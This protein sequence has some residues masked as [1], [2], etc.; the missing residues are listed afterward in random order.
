MHPTATVQPRRRSTLIPLS[1]FVIAFHLFIGTTPALT[2]PTSSSFDVLVPLPPIPGDVLT[3]DNRRNTPAI[4]IGLR[5]GVNRSSY[6]NDRYLDNVQLDVGDVSGESDIYESGAGFGYTFGSEVEYP[7]NAGLSLVGGVEYNHAVFGAKGPV[8]EPCISGSDTTRS[9]GS[10]VHE[11]TGT[12]N[13]LKFSGVGKLSFSKLYVLLG[14]TGEHPLSSKL[15]RTRTLEGGCVYADTRTASNSE[16]GPIPDVT[17]LHFSLRLG[18]GWRYPLTSN[19]TFSPE[20]ALDFGFNA[21]NKSKQSDLGI[22]SLLATI[23][24]DL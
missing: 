14:L 22:Y 12:I 15:E 23:R 9:I 5:A 18:V 2:Q 20:I 17:E 3:P 24:Y 4:K 7:I 16:S 11:Y 8:R 13:Y 1:L 19:I 21:I 6:S 10:S